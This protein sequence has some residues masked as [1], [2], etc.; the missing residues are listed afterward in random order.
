MPKLFR[1]QFLV[2]TRTANIIREMGVSHMKRHYSLIQQ[3]T[4]FCVYEEQ[5]RTKT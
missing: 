2:S 5:F 3:S 4:Y 1:T